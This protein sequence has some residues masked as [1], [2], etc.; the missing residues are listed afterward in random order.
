[1]LTEPAPVA[2]YV[3]V[4]CS[5]FPCFELFS[6]SSQ[7]ANMKCYEQHPEFYDTR[8]PAVTGGTRRYPAVPG[9]TRRQE[10]WRIHYAPEM[11]PAAQYMLR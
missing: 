4:C 5:M 10:A 8:C 7:V 2:T 1:M 3:S 11:L 6:S 9:G